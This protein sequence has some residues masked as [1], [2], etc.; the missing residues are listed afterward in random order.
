MT[1]VTLPDGLTL[2]ALNRFEALLV[3][4]EIVSEGWYERHGITL[5]PGSCVFDVGAN[6]GLFSI[7]LAR[8]VAGVRVR[9]FELVP[10]TFA[11]LQKNLT[12]HAP[13]VAAVPAGLA[14]S[15]GGVALAINRFSSV[16]MAA[17]PTIFTRAA[18]KNVTL[19]EW[20][21]A[22]LI[23]LDRVEPSAPARRL[24]AALASPL[25]RPVG[26]AIVVATLVFREA[27]KRLFMRRETC[28][29]RTLSAE[30]AASGFDRL[31]L[32]KIDVE[33]AE[34][35][36]LRGVDEADWPRI[37]QLVIEVH[38]LDGR[39]DRLAAELARRGYQ[40]VHDQEDWALH[41]LLGISTL[42]AVRR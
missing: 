26:L 16:D 21:T 41:P 30:L 4:R 18:V 27:R 33:G 11:M 25:T 12:E 31:D 13:H 22:G 35:D 9:C 24:R 42:F 28:E 14:A 34:E 32:V 20:A 3:Y 40:V 1:R 7:H 39:R 17:D 8:R 6:I 37:R 38:D 2:W 29:L 23:D 15:P 36:V 19:R 5:A 10:R